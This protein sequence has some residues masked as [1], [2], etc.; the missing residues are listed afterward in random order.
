LREHDR[1]SNTIVA[2][3]LNTTVVATAARH[4]G[5]CSR[6]GDSR[7]PAHCRAARSEQARAPAGI[8]EHHQRRK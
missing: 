7:A 1:V 6:R 8:G 4:T 2:S 3:S 5:A